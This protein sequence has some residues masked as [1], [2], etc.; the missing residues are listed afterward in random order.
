MK[1]II[2]KLHPTKAKLGFASLHVSIGKHPQQPTST[3]AQTISCM[4]VSYFQMSHHPP[5]A[6][7]KKDNIWLNKVLPNANNN[8]R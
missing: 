1:N 3:K 4:C 7:D 6:K 8:S 2:A 5:S